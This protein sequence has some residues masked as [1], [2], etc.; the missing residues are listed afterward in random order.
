MVWDNPLHCTPVEAAVDSHLHLCLDI[1]C[2]CKERF[3]QDCSPLMRSHKCLEIHEKLSNCALSLT[4][5]LLG[6]YDREAQFCCELLTRY[7]E[8]TTFKILG[9]MKAIKHALRKAELCLAEL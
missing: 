8:I 6:Y 7:V 3:P 1:L 9:G 2:A 4:P 5:G